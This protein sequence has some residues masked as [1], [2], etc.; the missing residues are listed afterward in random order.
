MDS[1]KDK[2][3]FKKYKE[4]VKKYKEADNR[5]GNQAELK[6]LSGLISAFAVDNIEEL[7]P[8][9]LYSRFERNIKKKTD[10]KKKRISF[11]SDHQDL[12]KELTDPVFSIKLKNKVNDVLESSLM[13]IETFIVEEFKQN[14]NNSYNIDIVTDPYS[15]SKY[16]A[17]FY[18][19]SYDKSIIDGYV[20]V[21]YKEELIPFLREKYEE[22]DIFKA[23]NT[24]RF[25]ICSPEDFNP[26]TCTNSI[27]RK[28]IQ[29]FVNK[30]LDF[31]RTGM[32][33]LE[34]KEIMLV[35]ETKIILDMT[36]ITLPSDLQEEERQLNMNSGTTLSADDHI[37]EQ[38]KER[39]TILLRGSV[40]ASDQY[41]GFFRK[42]DYINWLLPKFKQVGY[43]KL[44]EIF[45]KV[46]NPRPPTGVIK[47]VVPS[48][49]TNEKFYY[50]I[51]MEE[52]PLVY[53]Y[54]RSLKKDEKKLEDYLNIKKNH[55]F[56]FL[57]KIFKDFNTAH[58]TEDRIARILSTDVNVVKDMI[59]YVKKIS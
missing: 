2:E 17:Y 30:L 53:N 49:T 8:E 44:E 27:A 55:F 41:I 7:L 6:E 45:N 48:K 13:N 11:L 42:E 1:I 29:N 34:R 54:M 31:I 14:V 33:I 47:F 25:A 59:K 26:D 22:S 19:D 37:T 32:K 21:I 3:Q 57:Q 56:M 15:Y 4:L 24:D 51:S 39:F 58:Y 36:K 20:N 28:N 52:I 46:V 43:E 16:K 18:F 50:F 35:Y 12:K 23:V 10:R 38:I 5:I 40:K 9:V